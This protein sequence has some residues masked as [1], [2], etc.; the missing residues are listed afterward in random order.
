MYFFSFLHLVA[1]PQ[2]FG[3]IFL[4]VVKGMGL[5]LPIDFCETF[6]LTAELTQFD[7]GFRTF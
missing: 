4:G 1:F 5:N 3:S 6:D 7:G 2:L